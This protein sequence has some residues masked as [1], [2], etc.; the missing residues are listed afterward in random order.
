MPAQNTTVSTV[1]DVT[2][3][4]AATAQGAAAGGP[5]GAGV[6][7]AV[8]AIK[9][10]ISEL[11]QHTARLK[12]ATA[13]N[14]AMDAVIA[15]FDA[16]IAAIVTAH[17]NGSASAA[18][19]I[20]ACLIV[21]QNIFQ[22]LYSLAQTGK[23]GVAWSGPTTTSI[24]TANRPVYSADCNKQCTASCCVYLNDLRPSI[25][26]R[27]GLG[28]AYQ[29]YQTNGVII[30]LIELI[31][32]GNG[33]LKAIPVAPPSNPKYGTY[34]RAAYTLQIKAPPVQ[35]LIATTVAEMTGGGS[36][37]LP[38][39]TVVK[40]AGAGTAGAALAAMGS[41]TG[42]GSASTTQTAATEAAPSQT[43]ANLSGATSALSMPLLIVL[44]IGL[45]VFAL[46]FGGRR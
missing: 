42:G 17:N 8:A 20:Q 43:S 31:Q 27:A 38:D 40:A 21:D 16:D 37:A 4:G 18:T 11:T 25:F 45:L 33:T 2:Q 30:G 15:P 32:K 44:G 34:T 10:G 22:Y 24:G 14:T 13:E 28:N 29:P 26:G 35:A 9:V 12:N 39:G 41:S 23:P 5:I 6:A 19:C 1:S 7:G 36:I 46:F 3:I